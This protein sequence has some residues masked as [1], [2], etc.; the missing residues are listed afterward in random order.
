MMH[1]RGVKR[2]LY[3]GK[4]EKP[5]ENSE[6]KRFFFFVSG[7]NVGIVLNISFV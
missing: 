4:I 5:N 7:S 3:K 1:V 2:V 6:L